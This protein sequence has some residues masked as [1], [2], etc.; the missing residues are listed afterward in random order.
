[1]K[2]ARWY[3]K[4][5]IR[6]C[7]VPEPQP[8][9]GEVKIEVK[10]CGICGSDMGIYEKGPIMEVKPPVTLGHEFSGDVVEVGEGVEGFEVGDRVVVDPYVTCGECFWCKK[11]EGGSLCNQL[12]IIGYL[13]DGG[14]ARYACVPAR[15]TYKIGSLSYDVAALTQPTVLGVH[16]TKR[17]N[18][19]KGETALIMGAGPVGIA[20]IQAAKALG[21]KVIAVE[22]CRTRR[23]FAKKMGADLVLDPQEVNVSK[24]VLKH[25]TLGVDVAFECVGKEATMKTCFELTRKGG[26]VVAVGFS[27]ASFPITVNELIKAKQSI[28]G[29]LGYGDEFAWA[30]KILQETEEKARELITAKIKLEEIVD[31]GFKELINN[32][33]KHIKILVSPG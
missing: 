19:K 14:F 11:G 7:D 2:A 20:N 27:D 8:A 26:R 18:L 28:I 13:S 12:N 23:E 21:A 6:I 24:E 25:T 3:G 30:I 17:A 16:I 9:K 32:R 15:Q 31:K 5:D 33:D 10:W 4:G 22:I 29:T 1:M